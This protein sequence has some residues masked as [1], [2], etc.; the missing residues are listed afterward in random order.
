[1]HPNFTYGELE[2]G[3]LKIITEKLK[4]RLPS[5]FVDLGCG[6]G[7]IC[8]QALALGL[9]EKIYGQ[10]IVVKR[11]AQALKKRHSSIIYKFAD[12][13]KQIPIIS[14]P[15]LAYICATCFEH[16]LLKAIC[17]QIDTNRYYQACASL[18]PIPFCSSRW[19]VADIFSVQC[20]WDQ[21]L[22]YLYER[23]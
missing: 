6:Q 5:I 23:L 18:K 7:E 11:L 16:D 3:E 12:L 2:N 8:Q 17:H 10:E 21:S 1:M 13:S 22:C 9:F 14:K 20:S 15:G 19:T 4:D